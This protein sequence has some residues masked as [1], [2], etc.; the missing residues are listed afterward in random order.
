MKSFEAQEA[1]AIPGRCGVIGGLDKRRGSFLSDPKASESKATL[2]PLEPQG[3]KAAVPG[4]GPGDT[5]SQV[6]AAPVRR[7]YLGCG[8]ACPTLI[9][10]LGRGRS[11]GPWWQGRGLGEESLCVPEEG[12]LGCWLKVVPKCPPELAGA[13]LR[14]M[15]GDPAAGGVPEGDGRW[16]VGSA[17]HIAFVAATLSFEGN[18]E[19]RG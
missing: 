15:G 3:L 2:T 14:H 9:V 7:S 6:P 17:G 11:Q 4:D 8:G 10:N 12:D 16:P 13:V 18:Q 19:L 5:D 1:R